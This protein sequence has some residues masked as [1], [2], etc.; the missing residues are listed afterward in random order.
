MNTQIFNL[1]IDVIACVSGNTRDKEEEEEEVKITQKA[2]I[3]LEIFGMTL[4][5]DDDITNEDLNELFNK[6][7]MPKEP[8]DEEIPPIDAKQTMPHFCTTLLLQTLQNRLTTLNN[9]TS[10]SDQCVIYG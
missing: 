9:E 1:S 10:V 6:M 4:E 7:L 2:N 8:R 5:E 3:Y